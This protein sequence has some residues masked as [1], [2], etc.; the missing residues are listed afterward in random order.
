MH[1]NA[2]DFYK[3][4]KV[5]R[6]TSEEFGALC[7]ISGAY[8]NMVE[9]GKRNLTERVKRRLIEEL[10]LTPDKLARIQA[11]FNEFDIKER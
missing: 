9:H 10:E 2:D 8:V 5:Y 1:L 3:I 7:E 6:L 11:V 4:R